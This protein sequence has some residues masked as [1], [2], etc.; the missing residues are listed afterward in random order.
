MFDM[1]CVEYMATENITICGQNKV[2]TEDLCLLVY[3]L[4]CRQESNPRVVSGL[5]CAHVCAKSYSFTVCIQLM[6][7]IQTIEYHV[8]GT[9]MASPL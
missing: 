6:K 8:F 7:Y 3:I 4:R 9:A 5:A 1:T 2:C